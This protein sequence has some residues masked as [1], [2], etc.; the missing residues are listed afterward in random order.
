MVAVL[1]KRDARSEGGVV[2]VVVV[3]G[4]SAERRSPRGVRRREVTGGASTGRPH[5]RLVPDGDVGE[6]VHGDGAEGGGERRLRRLGGG[7]VGGAPDVLRVARRRAHLPDHRVEDR[8]ARRAVPRDAREELRV[9]AQ[10]HGGSRRGGARGVASRLVVARR[11]GV[12]LLRLLALLL[13]LLLLLLR[14]F[15]LL[16][17]PRYPVHLG[18]RVVAPRSVLDVALGQDAA[19]RPR[20]GGERR[21]V[22]RR[23]PRTPGPR[24]PPSG[25]PAGTS[26]PRARGRRNHPRDRRVRAR[27]PAPRTARGTGRPPGAEAEARLFR[28]RLFRRRLFRR[29]RPRGVP[30]SAAS[31][32]SA[33]RSRPRG[34]GCPR[35]RP[36]RARPR[37]S[38][39]PPPTRTPPTRPGRRG[40]PQPVRRRAV[41]FPARIRA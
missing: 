10:V 35:P 25:N 27:R 4:E 40:V 29:R 20:G 1:K 2:R 28:R 12:A 5:A 32:A 16:R 8:R 6:G 3:V 24:P 15:L 7:D 22:R 37:A 21:R 34:A 18:V 26:P 30:P 9:R 36:R 19:R 11:G 23:R 38:R 14:L 41:G 17:R 33:R 39:S 31:T 13:R